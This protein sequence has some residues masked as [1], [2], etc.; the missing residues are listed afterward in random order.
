MPEFV[1][2]LAV[3]RDEAFEVELYTAPA[4]TT[5]IH[6]ASRAGDGLEWVTI[7]TWLG[8]TLVE[9]DLWHTGGPNKLE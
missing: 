7:S 5:E 9:F 4:E 8:R 6:V 2:E 1:A 3:E